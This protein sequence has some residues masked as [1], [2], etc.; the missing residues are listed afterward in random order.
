MF[1]VPAGGGCSWCWLFNTL[2]THLSS[3]PFPQPLPPPFPPTEQSGHAHCIHCHT[4]ARH[5]PSGTHRHHPPWHHADAFPRI[6]PRCWGTDH[7]LATH[8][9]ANPD[10]HVH[11]TDDEPSH[12]SSSQLLTTTAAVQ[13]SQDL[14]TSVLPREPLGPA[15]LPGITRPP[16]GHGHG[17]ARLTWTP[18]PRNGPI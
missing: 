15:L 1:G 16:S 12:L 5:E 4:N 6:P 9:A 8:D 7:D 18:T 10:P 17:R 2:L 14:H 13:P 3:S 11:P